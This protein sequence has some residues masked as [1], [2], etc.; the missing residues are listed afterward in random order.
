MVEIPTASLW[1]TAAGCVLLTVGVIWQKI[2][3]SQAGWMKELETLGQPRAHK[4]PGTAIV[5]GGSIAGT[6][7][8][9]IL[10]DHFERVVLVDPEIEDEDKPKTRIMQYNATHILLSL[11][12]HGARRLWPN[13]DSEV[14]AAGGRVVP[15][16]IQLHYSGVLLPSPFHEYPRC[17]LPDTLVMRRANSQKVLHRLLMQHSTATRIS[18]LAGTV[19][20]VQPSADMSSIQSV[21]VRK[22]DG[23]QVPFNDVALVADCT[24]TT[25]AGFKWLKSAGFS[26]PD[27]IR[28]TYNGNLQY[29]TICFTVPP[30]LEAMLPIPS[31]KGAT[32]F[33]NIQ[34]Y[35][36]GSAILVLVKTDNNT[37]QLCVGDSDGADLPRT[38]SDV[39]P[40]LMGYGID[41]P[42]PSWILETISILCERGNPWFDD[43]KIPTLSYIQYHSL[44]AGGLPSNFVAIGD[45]NLKLNPIHG[46]GFA[47]ILL[48]GLALNTL[49]NAIDS[50]VRELPRDFSVRYF[51]NNAANTQGLWDATRLHDYG[52]RGCQ[53]MEG[54]TKDTGRFAR[55]F[56]L[57]LVSAAA[58]DDEAASALWHVRHLLAADR[59]LFAPTLLWKILWT[60]SLF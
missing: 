27:D 7:T 57:K 22:L 29:S 52:T 34:H 38:V 15:A 21:I 18:V 37:M 30:E 14:L 50:R 43:I 55:W 19:R 9:R 36:Y 26:F 44:P 33:I 17:R 48:N 45:A 53:P 6:V 40:F 54:E 8:A 12:V 16:D 28:R 11:F 46:Q 42:I 10:A 60:R 47:K 13:F 31:D 5:C 2:C 39:L 49:L 24:G 20:G 41:V 3:K 35:P 58:Q 32:L 56:E 4:L 25:Q 51:K 23:T 1:L 59:I